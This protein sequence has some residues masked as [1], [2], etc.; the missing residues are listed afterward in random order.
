MARIKGNPVEWCTYAYEKSSIRM[1][2]KFLSRVFSNW[3]T[4]AY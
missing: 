1:F 3:K 4:N 2:I